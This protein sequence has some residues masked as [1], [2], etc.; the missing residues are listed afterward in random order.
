ML[1][2]L[3]LLFKL[4]VSSVGNPRKNVL[5]ALN[6][7]KDTPKAITFISKKSN[8]PLKLQYSI[9]TIESILPGSPLRK[10]MSTITNIITI[11]DMILFNSGTINLQK[12]TVYSF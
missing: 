1:T 2:N 5:F 7:V 9:L 12:L 11:L 8:Q 4:Y 10:E 3:N 6:N